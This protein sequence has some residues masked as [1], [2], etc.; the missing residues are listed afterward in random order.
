MQQGQY[1]KKKVPKINV[2]RTNKTVDIHE[3][4]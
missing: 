4:Y 2:K 1:H 3:K